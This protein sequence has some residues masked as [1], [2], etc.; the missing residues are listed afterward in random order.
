MPPIT[1]PNALAEV[2]KLSA[3]V[4]TAGAAVRAANDDAEEAG[5]RADTLRTTLTA[6][7][8]AEPAPEPDLA[9]EL[10]DMLAANPAAATS[11]DWTGKLRAAQDS[12]AAA[13]VAWKGK[14]TI[15]MQALER[16]ERER[17]GHLDTLADA[18][19]AHERAWALFVTAAREAMTDEFERRFAAFYADVMGPLD[20]LNAARRLYSVDQVYSG[21][22]RALSAE[23]ALVINRPNPNGG[24]LV[25]DRHLYPV[26]GEADGRAILAAFRTSLGYEPEAR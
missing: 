8:A 18:K 10:S 24:G 25:M 26:A 15:I 12:T 2:A 17:A 5:R 22:R 20:A 11:D 21:P 4:D 1:D 13:I 9:D 23:S 3:A 16:V 19:A 6:H 7:D 14:R